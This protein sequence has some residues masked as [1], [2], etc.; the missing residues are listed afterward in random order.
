VNFALASLPC[1]SELGRGDGKSCNG[2]FEADVASDLGAGL[3]RR[4]SRTF[5]SEILQRKRLLQ[6]GGA[7]AERARGD[8][9]IFGVA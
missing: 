4:T 6:K 5:L 7:G 9:G 3:E 8:D 1:R 2:Q